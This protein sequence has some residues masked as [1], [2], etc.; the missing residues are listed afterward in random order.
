MD[1]KVNGI[2]SALAKRIRIE[3]ESRHWTLAMLAERSGVSKAMISK[4]E[5]GATSP[6]AALLGKLSGAFGLTLS[7][8]LEGVDNNGGRLRRA[9]EQPVWVDPGTGYQRRQIS[10]PRVSPVELVD[11]RLPAGAHVAFPAASYAFIRQVFWALE[12]SFCVTE[13]NETHRLY[14]GDS[15]A[16]G[17][18]MDRTVS[19]PTNADCRYLVAVA[20]L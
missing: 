10:P 7:A 16:L 15:L 4:I 8:L 20:R 13:G 17:E 1:I 2:D 9:Q 14:P 3:R 12:G 18:P 11:I 5:R 6:T 19:N